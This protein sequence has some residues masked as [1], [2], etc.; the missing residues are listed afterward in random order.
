MQGSRVS[1]TGGLIQYSNEEW[2]C[3]IWKEGKVLE[4]QDY[5]AKEDR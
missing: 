2:D 5:E 4:S 1:Q 3:V